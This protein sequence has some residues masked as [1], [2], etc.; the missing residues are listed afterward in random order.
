[1]SA[2]SP[3][4][5]SPLDGSFLRL[6]SPQAH[7][8]VGFSAV[9]SAPGDDALR[10]T[11]EALRER[12]ARRLHGVPWCRWRLQ[13]A[14][15]GLSEPRW[16]EDSTFDLD[17]H[18]IG[19]TEPD[20]RVGLEAFEALRD[21]TLSAPLD[22]TRPLWQ[23]ALIPRLADGRV[24]MVGKIHHSL[25]D[26]FA[27][28]QL[29][30]LVLDADA[31]DSDAEAPPAAPEP[32]QPA[33]QGPLGWALGGLVRTAGEGVGVA[34]GA[35]RAVVQPRTSVRGAIQEIGH[36]AQAVREDFLP[37]SPPSALNV[38]IGARRTLASYRA[39]RTHLRE[40]RSHGGTLNDIG[41]AVVTGALREL[42]L[43]HGDPP[44][45]PLKTM[46]P[47]SMRDAGDTQSGNRISMVYIGLPVHLDSPRQRLDE[48][49]AQTRRIKSTG[50]PYGTQTVFRAAGLLPAPVRSPVVKALASPRV[51]NLT[52]SQSPAPRGPL[53]LMGCELEE[54]YSVVPIAQGHA[55]AIGMVRY[56]RQ[57]FFG[58]YADPDA[59]PEIDELPALLEAELRALGG[60][61]E[62]RGGAEEE[63]AR[64]DGREP[65]L[66]R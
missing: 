23:V 36:V 32:W 18:V 44:L 21:S 6:D 39:P 3:S 8:H 34:R 5:L 60:Q 64:D 24:G 59:I 63:P 13:A 45:A 53:H 50:R 26:G 22:R 55:L 43:R 61:A 19:L 58:C 9:F 46:I 10:P 4:Q 51:F 7:M 41:L 31:D 27:A 66:V 33:G 49:R 65:A 12:V 54:P 2:E 35:A 30:A 15:L 11:V 57:L 48:V 47:V 62:D 56:N 38:P 28:L 42:S 25:V 16:V 1:M 20:A 14:P 40:A 17:A 37:A 52:V 29:V